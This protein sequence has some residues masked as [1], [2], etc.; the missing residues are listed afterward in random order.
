MGLKDTQRRTVEPMGQSRRT[1]KGPTQ[2]MVVK[3]LG[4][5]TLEPGTYDM[6]L[7]S[8]GAVRGNAEGRQLFFPRAAFLRRVDQVIQSGDDS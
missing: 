7:K 3:R 1:G 4:P 8:A 6:T 5:V 2:G